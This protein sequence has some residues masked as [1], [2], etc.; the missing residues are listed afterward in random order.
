MSKKS[1]KFNFP[2]VY[3]GFSRGETNIHI[4]TE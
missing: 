1:Y 2:S 3:S 4:Q